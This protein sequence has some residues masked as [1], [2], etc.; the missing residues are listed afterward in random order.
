[1]DV[2]IIDDI[3]FL[4]GKEKTQDVFF[5]I[6][7]YLHQRGKQIVIT[8]DKA[9]VELNGME[10]RLI[11]RFKWG[12]SADLQIPNIETRIAILQKR[13]Y[14]DGIEI[15]SLYIS[16]IDNFVIKLSNGNLINISNDKLE[17]NS[18]NKINSSKVKLKVFPLNIEDQYITILYQ[19]NKKF[20]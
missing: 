5:H 2:L 18:L 12:L 14:K 3:Q 13:L 7:N 8:S 10:P 6:F 11:S 1:M 9:P 4:A 16:K 20:D 19:I 15:S 17:Y